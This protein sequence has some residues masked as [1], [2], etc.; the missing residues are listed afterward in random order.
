MEGVH[1]LKYNLNGFSF[2]HVTLEND[3]LQYS[4]L[5]FKFFFPG[6]DMG[7]SRGNSVSILS[8]YRL[9]D[10][11]SVPDR[12]KGIFPLASVSRP[13]L[14]PTQPPIRWVKGFISRG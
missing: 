5:V 2:N 12:S 1:K 7:K 10:R 4:G 14:R 9:D 13:A 8:D 6:V 3:L 11:G